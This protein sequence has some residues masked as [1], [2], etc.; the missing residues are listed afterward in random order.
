VKS[1]KTPRGGDGRSTSAPEVPSV[2]GECGVGGEPTIGRGDSTLGAGQWE[3][4]EEA[5]P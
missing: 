3:H 2:K 5:M 1:G 4:I